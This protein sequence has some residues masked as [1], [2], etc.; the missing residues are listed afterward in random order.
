MQN[1]LNDTEAEWFVLRTQ[2]KRE[3]IAAKILAD[4]DGVEVFC[5][6]IRYKKAT[7][8]G[9]IWWVEP[10]FPSYL[11]AKFLYPT[12]A[13]QVTASHG[14][15]NI[16]N[17]GGNTLSLSEEVVSQIREMVQEQNQDDIIEFTPTISEGDEVEI[18]DGAFK[19]ISGTVIEPLPSQ[20]RVKILIELLG[21]PQL[22][23]ID[24]YS[25]LLPQRPKPQ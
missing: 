23:D 22:V 14:V 16:V 9:K 11:L 18:S 19:G 20:E 10:L 5:P 1:R 4:I 21:Q 17:F 6:R 13:R 3:H 8:R 15:T 2:T 12:Y 25:L 7:R 24:L